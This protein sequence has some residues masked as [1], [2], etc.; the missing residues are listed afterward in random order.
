MAIFQ[1]WF[2]SFQYDGETHYGAVRVEE[3]TREN[4]QVEYQA[5]LE[6]TPLQGTF[7]GFASTVPLAL[8]FL[9]LAMQAEGADNITFTSA[10]DT[11]QAA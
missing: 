10:S 2:V 3:L 11:S 4:G 6:S 1:H 9:N 5:I 8:D 7:G